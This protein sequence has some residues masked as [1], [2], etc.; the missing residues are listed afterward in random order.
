MYCEGNEIYDLFG[1]CFRNG[2]VLVHSQS[3]HEVVLRV[4]QE[5]AI[6]Y[7]DTMRNL[8]DEKR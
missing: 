3:L 6:P 7:Q 1:K 2:I 5:F 4:R 8:N